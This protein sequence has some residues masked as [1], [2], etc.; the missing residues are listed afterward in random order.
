MHQIRVHLA[1]C[2]W[3][4]VGDPKYGETHWTRVNDPVLRTALARFPRQA[5]HAWRVRLPHPYTRITLSLE[6]NVPSDLQ[7]L[8]SLTGMAGKFNE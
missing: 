2:G 8:L 6:A 7:E 1:A 4:L 3:P 5:L